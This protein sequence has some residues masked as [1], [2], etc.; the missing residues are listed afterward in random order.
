MRK[1]DKTEARQPYKTDLTDAQ[2]R[3]VKALI[4]PAEPGGRPRE[5]ETREVLDTLLY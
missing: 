4:P 2:W 5:V 3:V 1:P